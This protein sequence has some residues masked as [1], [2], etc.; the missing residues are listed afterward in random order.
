M[1]YFY[2]APLE[3]QKILFVLRD[4]RQGNGESLANY[5]VRTYGH[6]IPLGVELWE[7]DEAIQAARKVVEYP[8]AELGGRSHPA[9]WN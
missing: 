5:Y 3:Y 7:Y 4:L 2:S 8:I 6:L 9:S 1:Y